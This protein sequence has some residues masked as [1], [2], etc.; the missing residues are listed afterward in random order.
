SWKAPWAWPCR[1]SVVF[2]QVVRS[3]PSGSSVGAADRFQAPGVDG[4]HSPVHAGDGGQTAGVR[5][6]GAFEREG[7]VARD[8]FAP[9]EPADAPPWVEVCIEELSAGR[10]ES[11]R[12]H[13]G[14]Q[15]PGPA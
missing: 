10:L 2:Q 6:E 4:E 7:V 3:L 11:R 15:D 12:A 5:E 1:K 13:A 8:R 9:D 14:H